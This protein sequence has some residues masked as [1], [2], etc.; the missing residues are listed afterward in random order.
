MEGRDWLDHTKIETQRT[1][2]R[3]KIGR[4]S[5]FNVIKPFSHDK[6]SEANIVTKDIG[7]NSNGAFDMVQKPTSCVSEPASFVVLNFNNVY[8]GFH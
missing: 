5:I 2:S 8:C 1:I 3:V 4:L 6:V 7:Q